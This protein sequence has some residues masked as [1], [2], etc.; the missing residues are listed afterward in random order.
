MIEI[1]YAILSETAS[2]DEK[3][4]FQEMMKREE[5]LLLFNR[6]TK[7]FG[8]KLKKLDIPKHEREVF[9]MVDVK[10]LYHNRLLLERFIDVFAVNP[11]TSINQDIVK[12]PVLRH[13]GR[14]KINELL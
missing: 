1:S 4:Q 6:D 7:K 14:L 3:L 12:V 5:N 13:Y 10:T 9:S 8:K 2:P 11:N